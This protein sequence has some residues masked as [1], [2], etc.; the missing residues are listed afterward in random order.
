MLKVYTLC[1][2]YI[3]M[4]SVILFIPFDCVIFFIAYI[5]CLFALLH[6]VCYIIVN[7]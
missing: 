6:C 1:Y 3:L 4:A 2:G 7:L 5:Y